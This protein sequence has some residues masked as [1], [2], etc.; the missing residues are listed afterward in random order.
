MSTLIVKNLAA[1]SLAAMLSAGTPALA[2]APRGQATS[3]A[4]VATPPAAQAGFYRNMQAMRAQMSQLRNATDPAERAKLLDAHMRMMQ[5]T[6][7][8]M[9]GQ[10]GIGPGHARWHGA[11]HDAGRQGQPRD[12]RQRLDDA[13]DVGTDDAASAGDA[14]HRLRGQAVNGDPDHLRCGRAFASF[15]PYAR[16]NHH[17]VRHSHSRMSAMTSFSARP[18]G[19][20]FTSA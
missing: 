14:G 3:A 9:A 17:A 10:G 6:M 2:A 18:R 20:A 7:Q 15:H 4:S 12:D 16:A 8:M 5:A 1:C 11:G 19:I 13:D